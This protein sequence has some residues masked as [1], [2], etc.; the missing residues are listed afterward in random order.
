MSEECGLQA[1]LAR[2]GVPDDAA[3][4]AAELL[5]TAGYDAAVLSGLRHEECTEALREHGEMHLMGTGHSQGCACPQDP[6][7]HTF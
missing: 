2:H 7:V 6:L 1:W 3:S 5:T 4:A